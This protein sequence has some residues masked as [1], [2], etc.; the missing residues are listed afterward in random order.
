MTSD[1]Q[2]LQKE[3]IDKCQE[4]YEAVAEWLPMKGFIWLRNEET[5]QLMVYT[6]GEYTTQI[7]EFLKGLEETI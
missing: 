5:G 4:Y 7:M 3:T 1:M 2:K 6:R